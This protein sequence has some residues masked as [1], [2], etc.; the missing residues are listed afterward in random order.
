MIQLENGKKEEE[1]HHFLN[2]FR[3]DS[4]EKPAFAYL[5]HLRAFEES[6]YSNRNL[7]LKLK[8]H[9]MLFG[10]IRFILDP[11][12]KYPKSTNFLFLHFP[13]NML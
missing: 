10:L 4:D 6:F 12:T 9:H 2:H 1:I 11:Q 13:L 7:K 3:H 8:G 5:P